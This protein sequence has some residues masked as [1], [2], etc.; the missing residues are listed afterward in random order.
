MINP[1]RDPDSVTGTEGRPG[2]GTDPPQ[3]TDHTSTHTYTNSGKETTTAHEKIST[4][5][6]ENS[7]PPEN[8][9]Y[10][11]PTPTYETS[12]QI[13]ST[14]EPTSTSEVSTG[15][16]GADND[17]GGGGLP[18]TTKVAIAVP[19]A[20]VGTIILAALLFFLLKRRQRKRPKNIVTSPS[21]TEM[22]LGPAGS[23]QQSGTVWNP[24]PAQVNSSAAFA[25]A[26]IPRRPVPQNSDQED[27]S[28]AQRGMSSES[29]RGQSRFREHDDLEDAPSG[30]PV[31]VAGQRAS[32]DRPRSQEERPQSPFDHPLDD[33]MSDI[34]ELSGRRSPAHHRGLDDDASS[35]SSFEDDAGRRSRT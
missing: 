5:P 12:S 21:Q 13:P 3:P 32:T 14:L 18:T 10:P 34:S 19:V 24:Q 33:A 29:S 6:S 2:E 22:S 26:S 23:Q 8:S 25:A 9:P 11:L 7:A 28:Q 31:V 1:T 20:V 35:V 16:D 4:P 27:P 30:A 17:S 15:E